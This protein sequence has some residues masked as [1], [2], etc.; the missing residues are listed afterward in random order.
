MDD[1]LISNTSD[2]RKTIDEYMRTNKMY[3]SI[4]EE[5]RDEIATLRTELDEIRNGCLHCKENFNFVAFIRD[6]LKQLR[7]EIREDI[8]SHVGQSFLQRLL[9]MN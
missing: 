7:A 6:E 3:E 4:I 5:L 9:K 2:T 8:V 1:D